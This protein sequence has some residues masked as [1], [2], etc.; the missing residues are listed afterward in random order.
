MDS[1]PL[2]TIIL[3]TSLP[4]PTAEM[5]SVPVGNSFIVMGGKIGPTAETAKVFAY[6][7]EHEGGG[8]GGKWKIH[9]YGQLAEPV[10]GTF[11]F[12]V[13]VEDLRDV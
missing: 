11:A 12:A 6:V 10:S 1:K 7:P 3:A 4:V 2:L 8:G 13:D 5:A 9:P